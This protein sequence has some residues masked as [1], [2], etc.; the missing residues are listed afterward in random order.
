M[1]KHYL[2]PLQLIKIAIE[3]AYCAEHLLKNDGEIQAPNENVDTLFAAITLIYLAFELALKAYLLHKTGQTKHYKNLM[4]LVDLNEQ[5]GLEKA[6]KHVI[7]LLSKQHAFK[8]GVDYQIWI[9]RQELQVFCENCLNLF[10][11]LQTFTPI[12]LQSEYYE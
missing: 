5:L 9:N 2:E 7:S 10:A 1:E 4:E 6:E 11:R 12:E 3:H 8:K